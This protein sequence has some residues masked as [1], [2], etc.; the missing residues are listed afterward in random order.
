MSCAGCL[1]APF[2]NGL[3]V[4]DPQ[5]GEAFVETAYC[6]PD[7]DGNIWDLQSLESSG[8][9]FLFKNKGSNTCM[10]LKGR[11]N[12]LRNDGGGDDDDFDDRVENDDENIKNDHRIRFG[13][14]DDKNPKAVWALVGGHIINFQCFVN[15]DRQGTPDVLLEAPCS[16]GDDLTSMDLSSLGD[17]AEE[18][19][20]TYWVLFPKSFDTSDSKD[21]LFDN[22]P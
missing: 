2:D 18:A 6:D 3:G 9:W 4:Y 22:F 5:N 11:C 16:D 14:C 7:W 17:D 15:R 21:M 19:A 20:E 1:E 8:T 10:E 12:N 13:E